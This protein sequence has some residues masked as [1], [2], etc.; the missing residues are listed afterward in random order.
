LKSKTDIMVVFYAVRDQRSVECRVEDL[1]DCDMVLL[2]V[3]KGGIAYDVVNVSGPYVVVCYRR[4]G[5]LR[6]ILRNF[7]W[8]WS[9]LEYCWLVVG[10]AFVVYVRSP[11]TH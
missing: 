9:S 5:Q 10:Y 3:M 8:R 2:W 1:H 7:M 4:V 6:V 11:V